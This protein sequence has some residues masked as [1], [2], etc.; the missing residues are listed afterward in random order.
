MK[1]IENKQLHHLGIVAGMCKE[2]GIG[3][4][5]DS[6]ISKPKRKVSVGEATEA[7]IINA[8]GFTGRALYLTPKF[9]KNKPTDI[10]IRDGIKETDLNDSCLG[11]ALDA[12]YSAG[13]TELFY[14]IASSAL[15]RFHIRH[16]FV[17]LDTTSFS[18]Y[19][20]YNSEDPEDETKVV[21]I[22]KGL[23]KDNA[24]ELNQVVVSLMCT[25]RS[26]IP[27]WIETLSGNSSDKK[28]FLE[29][30]KEYRANFDK[31][32][33]PHF[34]CD[35]A[36]YTEENLKELKK[37]RW[38]TRVP[39]T[40]NEA[41]EQIANTNKEQMT[42]LEDGYSYRAVKSKYAGINQR[43]LIVF[44]QKAYE[45]EIKTFE[46][47]LEKETELKNKEL[48]HLG[49]K[50]FACE[51]DALKAVK[52]F[53]KKLKYHSLQ[54]TIEGRNQYSTK[55]RPTAKSKPKGL[56]YFIAGE[57][58][59][60]EKRIQEKKQKKGMFIIATNDMDSSRLS[61]EQLVCVYK[62]QGVSVERGFRFL[63]DPLF[64]A[65]SLYLK[66][67]SRIMALIMVMGLSLL[68]YALAERKIRKVMKE[69][70]VVIKNQKRKPTN[71]PTIRWVFQVF[72]GILY[73]VVQEGKIVS[74]MTM[75][76]EEDHRNILACLGP[77]Y[78][79]IYFLEN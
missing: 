32:Q 22:T 54:F 23:S 77:P 73:L 60:D 7:M 62:A 24:P 4:I 76:V 16:K 49:N 59:E 35:S 1:V 55:G 66:S 75:N 56:S 45:R 14:T 6:Y 13:L 12:L 70:N 20:K 69:N 52:E 58:L 11:T 63:K 79:K 2:I 68:V 61:N 5:I 15:R 53:N 27:I 21:K 64:Y 40:L 67:P 44:S 17:H 33:L 34:V 19:G 31:K 47:N 37:I 71:K 65:E 74:R 29:T 25:Y 57:L 78:E 41:K 36:L 26:S 10:L 8:L 38:V 9:M 48:W 3:Q 30:I 28:N 51:A 18:L 43:W 72:E 42:T 50:A 46:K 39:E